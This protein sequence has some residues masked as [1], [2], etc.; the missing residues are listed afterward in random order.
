M[1][2]QLWGHGVFE[3]EEAFRHGF[4]QTV[5]IITTTGLASADFAVWPAVA[6]LTILALMFVGGSAGSTAG[7]IKVIRHLLIG[8]ILRR[9][10]SQTLSPEVV[11]PIRLNGSPVD[12]RTLRAIAAFVLLYVGAWVVGAGIIAVDSAIVGAGFSSLDSIGA[13]ATALGN[14]GPGFGAAGPYGSFAPL[15]DV[16]KLTM[17]ALMY[18]G[19]LEIVPVIVVL[20]RHYWRL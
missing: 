5:S 4:F 16:S 6:L 7:S 17:I 20:T 14:V 10:L 3:G 13:S 12:E 18:L 19:R 8:K 9:E 11:L 2:I 15:G 1:T